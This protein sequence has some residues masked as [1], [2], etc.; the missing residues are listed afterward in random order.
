MARPQP[1]LRY[2]RQREGALGNPS[3]SLSQPLS[4]AVVQGVVSVRIS[5]LPKGHA[6]RLEAG[7]KLRESPQGLFVT[8]LDMIAN[9]VVGYRR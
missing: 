4:P 7:H 8:E 3:P 5:R 2:D 6:E 9:A 1:D